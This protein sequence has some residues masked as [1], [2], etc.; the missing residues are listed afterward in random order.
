MAVMVTLHLKK[1]M[2]IKIKLVTI[3]K[4]TQKTNQRGNDERDIE[5]ICRSGTQAGVNDGGKRCSTAFTGWDNSGAGAQGGGERSSK[6]SQGCLKLNCVMQ[7]K[8]STIL[9]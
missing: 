1:T 4:I 2:V 9:D 6:E 7:L 3:C 5:S 8:P